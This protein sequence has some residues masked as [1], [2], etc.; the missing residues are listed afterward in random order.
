MIGVDQFADITRPDHEGRV[1]VR[2]NGKELSLRFDW[3][4]IQGMQSEWGED[5]FAVASRGMDEN[6]ITQLAQV[7]SYGSTLT[8]DEVR[9]LGLPI[10]PVAKACRI[11]WQFAWFGGEVPD[12]PEDDA[13]KKTKPRKTLLERLLKFRSGRASRGAT[14]GISS[15]TQ[16]A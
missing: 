16:L 13:A 11:A 3:A 10:L 7:A 5:F 14:S 8:A 4:S 2:H 6:Q 1:I 15:P 9:G 12:E